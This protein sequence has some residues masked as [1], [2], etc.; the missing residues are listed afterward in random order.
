[1]RR[2]R[3]AYG[4]CAKSGDRV[5]L[6]QLVPDGQFRGMLVAREFYEPRHPQELAVQLGPEQHTMPAPEI[7]KPAD[8]G[9][10]AP[11]MTFNA[12][13]KLIFV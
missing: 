6:D 3:R 5:P 10:A 1:M 11:V 13:G 4:E 2:I 7:S 8:E 9:T 12:Q